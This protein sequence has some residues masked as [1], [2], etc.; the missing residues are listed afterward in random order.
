MKASAPAKAVAIASTNLRR[1][2][3]DR[4][5]LVF[6][7]ILPIAIILLI[8][9]QFSD[10]S[11]P[12]LGIVGEVDGRIAAQ[13]LEAVRTDGE[14][15]VVVLDDAEVLAEQ[16][17]SGELAGGVV[18][19]EG[20]DE[21]VGRGERTDVRF[22]AASTTQGQQLRTAVDGA[23]AEA[24]AG[25]AAVA[26][27][28]ELGAPPDAAAAALEQ[29]ASS[30]GELTVRTV[31]AGDRL[32]PEG[33]DGYEV[34]APSQLVLFT[35]VTGLSGSYALIQTRQL[36]LSRRMLSTPTSTTTIISGEALGRWCIC[37][38][39]AL[40]VLVATVVLFGLD[41]GDPLG[42]AA[43]VVLVAAVSAAAAMVFGTV[44]ENPDQASGVGVIAA[45][46]LAAL[47]GAMMP[48]ELFSDT[49]RSVARFTPH[50]WAIE[51]FAELVRHDGGVG[52][53]LPQLGVLAAYTAVLLAFAAWRM[54]VVLTRAAR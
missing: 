12:R 17:D 13:V 33:T 45:L 37:L 2:A 52:D 9:L 14:V 36:G 1:F 26:A 46:G 35:F 3:R 49:L 50:Y 27:A 19:P 47:G 53:I 5:N 43:L 24:T 30:G 29:S 7:F 32:F 54:R 48:L 8:G 51:G 22:V 38:V 16:V 21:Q 23:I 4:T 34:A 40:Y 20:L 15:E 31:T 28:V 6:V 39:Q 11:A 10:E 18:L 42:A 25:P 44:F 41:W